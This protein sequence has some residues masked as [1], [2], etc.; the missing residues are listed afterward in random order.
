MKEN[1][2][3]EVIELQR[4]FP[5]NRSARF[6]DKNLFIE[7]L[8]HEIIGSPP[9]AFEADFQLILRGEHDNLDVLVFSLDQG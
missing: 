8:G 1:A 2:E 5:F 3:V 6:G 4:F 9:H 7:G